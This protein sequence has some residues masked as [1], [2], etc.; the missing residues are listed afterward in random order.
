VRGGTLY[1]RW[2]VLEG[3]AEVFDVAANVLRIEF[4]GNDTT[5]AFRFSGGG[6]A[7]SVEVMGESFL[8]R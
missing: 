5:V 3:P 8:R 6:G 4:A 7:R 2:G 1:Y